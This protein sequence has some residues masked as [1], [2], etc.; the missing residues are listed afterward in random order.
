MDALVVRTAWFQPRY[1][2]ASLFYFD[3]TAQ[4]LVPEPVFVPVG[5]T[6]AT[7]LV[8][9]LL[10]GPPPRL[11]GVVR[12]FV[13]QGLQ[14]GLSVPVID[15]VAVLDLQGEWRARTCAAEAG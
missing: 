4:V 13:P 2:Q 10:A 9:A 3:P 11:R 8:S 5:E 1:R 15:G 6:F 12:S 14:V 7:N